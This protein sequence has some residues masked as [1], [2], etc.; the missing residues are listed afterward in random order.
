MP[1][2]SISGLNGVDLEEVEKLRRV[3][4]RTCHTLL[5]RASTPRARRQLAEASG[6]DECTILHWARIAD[7][8]RVRGVAQ[9]YAE[10]L[11]AAGVGTVKDLRRRNAERLTQELE[12]INKERKLVRLPPGESRV[13]AWI[14]AAQ[15]IEPV[16]AYRG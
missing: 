6:I 11:E 7:L 13:R 14:A 4:I 2:Y 8:T 15:A 5:A 3:G 10:L 12:K 16:L 1:S 9:E